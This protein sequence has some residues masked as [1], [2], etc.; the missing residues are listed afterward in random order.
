MIE[1]VF[2]ILPIF[3]GGYGVLPPLSGDGALF[4]FMKKYR[5]P[6]FMMSLLK[7]SQS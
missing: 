4:R 5:K 1:R 3:F 2:D 6:I 7:W